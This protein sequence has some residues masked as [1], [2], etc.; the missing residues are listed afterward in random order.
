MSYFKIYSLSAFQKKTNQKVNKTFCCFCYSLCEQ[1]HGMTTGSI[2]FLCKMLCLLV[3]VNN[4]ILSLLLSQHF[5][6]FPLLLFMYGWQYY[7][8]QPFVAVLYVVKHSSKASKCVGVVTSCSVL[9]SWHY[10]QERQKIWTWERCESQSLFVSFLLPAF[11]SLTKFSSS[12]HL[13]ESS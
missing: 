1:K 9:L 10:C 7:T 11:Q 13:E 3:L 4:P 5:D 8:L 2:F 6:F 12:R